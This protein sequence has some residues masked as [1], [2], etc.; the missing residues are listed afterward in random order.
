MSELDGFTRTSFSAHG[1]AR[2]VYRTGSG[3][4][5]IV[6][7]ELPGITPKVAEF[8]RRVAAIGCTAVAAQPVR[9]AGPGAVGRV[10]RPIVAPGVRLVGVRGLRHRAGESGHGVAAGAGQ[11][12]P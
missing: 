4:A 1:K 10:Y 11:A 5:V 7:S 2:D 8:G 3:P 6:I 9:P 12:R